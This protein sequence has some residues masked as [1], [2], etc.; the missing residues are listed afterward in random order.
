MKAVLL[1]FVSLIFYFR[2][3]RQLN[4]VSVHSIPSPNVNRVCSILI[5]IQ[6]LETGLRIS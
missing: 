1:E 5:M 2:N 6:V 3:L 4:T